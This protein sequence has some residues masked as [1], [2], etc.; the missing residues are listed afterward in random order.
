MLNKDPLAQVVKFK[1]NEC[2]F[3]VSHDRSL[4][5]DRWVEV[6]VENHLKTHESER[7]SA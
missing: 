6:Q 5:N 3:K 4:K 2:S 1:C 7:K